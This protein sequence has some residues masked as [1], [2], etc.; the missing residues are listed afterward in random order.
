MLQGLEGPPSM[1]NSPVQSPKPVAHS[2][3]ACP[4]KK[5]GRSN[6]KDGGANLPKLVSKM[7]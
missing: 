2:T 1:C 4:Q 3:G 5:Q 6:F 7:N